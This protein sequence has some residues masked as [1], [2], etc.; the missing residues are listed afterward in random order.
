MECTTGW[1][2]TKTGFIMFKNRERVLE[3]NILTNFILKDNNLITFEDKR[4]NGCWFGINKYFGLTNTL[5][6]YREDP[7]G[8]SSENENFEI[9]K[10]VLQKAKSVEEATELYKKLFFEQK[11]GKSY[12]VI[13]CDSQHANILELA[14]NKVEVKTVNNSVFR[15]NNFL[16]LKEY[17][18][19]P[20]IV[21]R[22][23]QRFKKLLELIKD[24]KKAEDIIP[25]LKYHSDNDVENICRHDYG[26]TIGSTILELKNNEIILYYLLN[27]SP[28]KGEYKKEILRFKRPS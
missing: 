15:A 16:F 24:V 22:S 18:K 9:N 19:E 7:E 20:R 6:P 3:K 11:I 21:D 27:K 5:G 23:E 28:C 14:P 1:I 12:S 25:I 10:E 4:F 26:T 2:K 17:N 8:F 13:I